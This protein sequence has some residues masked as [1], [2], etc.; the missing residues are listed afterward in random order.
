VWMQQP[1]FRLVKEA[2][3]SGVHADGFSAYLCRQPPYSLNQSLY[4]N[5]IPLADEGTP[6]SQSP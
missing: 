5:D 6:D 2:M 4:W 1:A 3:K